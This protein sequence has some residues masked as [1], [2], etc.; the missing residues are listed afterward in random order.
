M[1]ELAK[2]VHAGAKAQEDGRIHVSLTAEVDDVAS[3]RVYASYSRYNNVL[4]VQTWEE[5][6]SASTGKRQGKGLKR[7]I[8]EVPP[9]NPVTKMIVFSR[10][11]D[12]EEDIN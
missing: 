12:L 9:G 8:F 3:K 4:R 6:T 2:V 11:N 10:E 1:K 7:I 5:Q